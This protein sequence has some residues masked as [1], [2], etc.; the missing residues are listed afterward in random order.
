MGVQP[1]TRDTDNA[2]GPVTTDR[3]S[4][5]LAQIDAGWVELGAGRV[6]LRDD[7][8]GRS[9]S[10]DLQ[11]FRLARYP[12]TVGQYR[13]VLGLDAT[14]APAADD[15]DLPVVEVSWFDAVHFC[16]ALSRL[17]GRVPCYAVGD[18][19]AG[20]TIDGSSD[21]YRLPTEAEWQ[22]ACQ[23]GEQGTRYGAL[24]AIAWHRENAQ[25]R[26]H[27]V[28]AKQPNRWG[29]YDMIGNVWEWCWD[30]YDP[31]VYGPYRVFRGGGWADPHWGCTAATRR[32]SHPT[33]RID[34][35][36]FRLARNLPTAG[37]GR[38]D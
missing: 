9:W 25:G 2:E 1:P 24:D 19:S 33:F 21:G 15:A 34:D 17:A 36:G 10:V 20:V 26:R 11:P 27:P 14:D 12:V 8:V 32:R 35:L 31:Q 18:D 16:N 4:V 22:Y 29:L 13:G 7:R 5:V 6:G 23:A 30:L 37:Q 38:G 28:G 3:R